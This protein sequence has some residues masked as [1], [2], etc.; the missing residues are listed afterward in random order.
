MI[1]WHLFLTVFGKTVLQGKEPNF[2]LL[3]LSSVTSKK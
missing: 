3:D 2:Q 1:S